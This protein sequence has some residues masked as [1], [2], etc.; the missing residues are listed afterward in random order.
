MGWLYIPCAY[1][2]PPISK[3]RLWMEKPRELFDGWY[4]ESCTSL[5]QKQEVLQGSRKV[6]LSASFVS[7]ADDFVADK[8]VLKYLPREEEQNQIIARFKEQETDENT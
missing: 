5:I 6:G 7:C 1:S 3:N 8:N 4:F 2:Q